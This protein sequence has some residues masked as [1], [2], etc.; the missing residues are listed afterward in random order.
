MIQICLEFKINQK[1]I[2][3]VRNGVQGYMKLKHGIC[4]PFFL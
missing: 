3:K 2:G 1:K 4:T